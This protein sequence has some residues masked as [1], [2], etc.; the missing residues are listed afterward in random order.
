MI[1]SHIP[2]EQ[3][4]D[5]ENLDDLLNFKTEEINKEID[6]LREELKNITVKIL[7]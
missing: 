1:F 4:L 6:N 7:K 3:R 5:K 2:S